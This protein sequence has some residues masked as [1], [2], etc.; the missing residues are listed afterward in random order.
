PIMIGSGIQQ[1]NTLIDRILA[2]GLPEGSIAALNYSNRLGLF[3]I[4]LFSAAVYS[5]F[6]T[7]MSNYF[8]AGQSEQ[9]KKLLRNTINVSFILVLP[10]SAGFL[11]LR[12][13]IVKMIFERGLFDSSAS[14]VT[15]I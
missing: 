6:Y 11:V 1:I 13:P 7:S 8:T 4:N 12:L 14:E 9:F 15:A 2:S 3:I 10:A 5:V